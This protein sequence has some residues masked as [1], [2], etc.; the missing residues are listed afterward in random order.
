M[1]LQSE[2]GCGQHL[3]YNKNLK[4]N[5][6]R[7]IIDQQQNIVSNIT[8]TIPTMANKPTIIPATIPPIAAIIKSNNDNHQV[9]NEILYIH[10]TE[11]AKKRISKCFR[12]TAR[13][14]PVLCKKPTKFGVKLEQHLVLNIFLIRS[15]Q[16]GCKMLERFSI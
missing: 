4:N 14:S 3:Y 5:D 11:H 10:G 2:S 15:R 9:Q 12:S 7:C 13:F 8:V 6:M 1:L 16:Y